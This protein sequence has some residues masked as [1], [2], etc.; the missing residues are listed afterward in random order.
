MLLTNFACQSAGLGAGCIQE[1]LRSRKLNPTPSRAA[2]RTPSPGD[3]AVNDELAAMFAK[4]QIG[5]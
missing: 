2:P 3:A 1:E 5:A 4:R